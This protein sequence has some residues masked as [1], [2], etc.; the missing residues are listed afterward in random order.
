MNRFWNKFRPALPAIALIVAILLAGQAGRRLPASNASSDVEPES[1]YSVRNTFETSDF[2]AVWVPYLS[3]DMQRES[4]RHFGAFKAKF[5]AILEKVKECGANTVLVHVRSFGDAMYRSAYAPWSH[6]LTGVQ[7]QDPGYDALAYMV[8]AAHREGL[9]IHAWLNPL[10]LRSTQTPSVLSENN[11]YTVWKNDEDP[12]N[13]HW[14]VETDTGIYLNP[15]YPEVRSHLVQVVQELIEQYDVDGVHLDDYFYPTTDESFDAEAYD[16]YR[17]SVTEGEARSLQNWRMEQINQLIHD[18]YQT[19]KAYDST[20]QFGISPQGNMENCAEM[21]ADIATWGS[22][23]GYVDYLCPQ[24]YYPFDH[25]EKPF[26]RTA[27]EW[28]TMVSCPSVKLYGGLAL[29][30]AGDPN[31]DNGAWVG[32]DVI[33]Q[34]LSELERIG[35]QGFGLYSDAYLTAQQTAAEMTHVRACL[36]AVEPAETVSAAEPVSVETESE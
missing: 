36:G 13:D 31:V 9:S 6:L 23:E 24:L 25:S 35:Y 11:V 21:C 26:I 10:R 19:I 12:A 4:Q 22:Q 33:R 3:L 18:I 28:M 29:Y 27:E 15:A 1:V 34:Q 8:E 16:A 2:K 14:T 20:L 7:G 5:D 30:K 32:G 17:V